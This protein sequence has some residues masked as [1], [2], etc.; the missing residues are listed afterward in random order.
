VVARLR[1]STAIVGMLVFAI[2]LGMLTVNRLTIFSNPLLL[3]D[4]ALTLVK[5]RPD[6]PG[7]DRIYFNR[8]KFLTGIKRYQEA[9]YDNQMAV[10]LDPDFYYYRYGLAVAYMN[11]ARYP[12]AITTFTKTLEM[13]PEMS[14]SY[15]GRG[16]SELEVGS[17]GAALADFGKACELGWQSACKKMKAME[18]K[19]E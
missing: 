10:K 15:Y 4:D 14:Q 16:L 6:L 7:V 1:G 11:M 17:K 13:K 19:A 3:W 9:L 18:N 12:E 8:A 2:V 5:N